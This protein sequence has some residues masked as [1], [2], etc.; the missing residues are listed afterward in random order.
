MVTL[1]R[2]ADLDLPITTLHKASHA[3]VGITPGSA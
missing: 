3:E 1:S 2:Y